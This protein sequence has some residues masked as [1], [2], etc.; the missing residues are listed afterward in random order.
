[1]LSD[2]RIRNLTLVAAALALLPL[3]ADA[4]GRS[5]FRC[6]GN[7]GKK[8]YGN[9]VPPQCYGRLVEQLNAQGMVVKR[10]DPDASDKDVEA[11]AREKAEK[12][13]RDA[14]TRETTRRDRALLATYTSEKDIEEQRGRALADNQKTVREIEQRVTDL[15]KRRAS[16]DKELEFYQDKKGAPAKVPPKLQEEIRQA[17]FDLKVQ[18]E[19]LEVKKKEVNSI[20]AKYDE[21]KKRFIA[22]T[23]R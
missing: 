2:H 9:T 20:N 14:A 11:K 17:D 3:L 12:D 10:M 15:K 6:T 18:Q 22:L 19:S 13:K 5:T 7:D 21:D 8:Y 4:Q 1:M 23:K 16:F